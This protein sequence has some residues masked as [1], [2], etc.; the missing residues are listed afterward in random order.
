MLHQ[1]ELQNAL[2]IQE[3]CFKL[4]RWLEN[5]IREGLVTA[6]MAHAVTDESHAVQG[7]LEAHLGDIPPE[8]LPNPDQ[9]EPFAHFFSTYLETSFDFI[10]KPADRYVS[11][12]CCGCCQY[13]AAPQH[14]R[15]KSL[16]KADKDRAEK[17]RLRR[18][19]M[20]AREEGRPSFELHLREALKD[21]K[22]RMAASFS[23]YGAALLDRLKGISDGPAVLALWRHFAWNRNGS[24][25]H[26]FKLKTTQILHAEE[27]LIALL[28]QQAAATTP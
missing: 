4:L 22:V 5:A 24:P 11:A 3:R 15:P 16:T 20:L 19:E 7:W 2:E 6:S 1:A 27:T 25:I 14:V 26:G 13:L 17:L 9:M 18:L 23:A 21:E 8:C 10:A 28:Y 12:C